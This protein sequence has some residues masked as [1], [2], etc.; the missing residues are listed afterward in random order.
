[1]NCRWDVPGCIHIGTTVDK[2]LH[3]EIIPAG[4]GN[5]EGEDAVDNRVDGLAVIEC[6]GDEPEVPSGSSR[7]KAKLGDWQKR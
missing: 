5:V 7:V 6:I 3:Y 4:A 1:M 2:Q